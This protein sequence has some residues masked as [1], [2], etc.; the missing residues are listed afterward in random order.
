[1]LSGAVGADCTDPDVY[2]GD[3]LNGDERS[4]WALAINGVFFGEE[5]KCTAGIDLQNLCVLDSVGDVT[6][7]LYRWQDH[8]RWNVEG[9]S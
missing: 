3:M 1:M 8:F 6:D 9:S 2:L 4:R 5:G 7:Y